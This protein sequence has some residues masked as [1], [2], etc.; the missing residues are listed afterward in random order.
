[1]YDTA[2]YTWASLLSSLADLLP[3]FGHDLPVNRAF[4]DGPHYYQ[5]I[6]DLI[7]TQ[8]DEA[9]EEPKHKPKHKNGLPL[10]S[11]SPDWLCGLT[12]LHFIELG[13]AI[14]VNGTEMF[15]A[16]SLVQNLHKSDE[17]LFSLVASS[18]ITVRC[19]HDPSL[20]GLRADALAGNVEFLKI[21]SDPGPLALYHYASPCVTL[22]R[23]ISDHTE[24]AVRI[25]LNINVDKPVPLSKDDV[26][27]NYTEFNVFLPHQFMEL[28]IAALDKDKDKFM[29]CNYQNSRRRMISAK[30]RSVWAEMK[31]ETK[32]FMFGIPLHETLLKHPAFQPLLELTSNA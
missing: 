27:P 3:R 1:M 2:Y 6:N 16:L 24:S 17:M 32:R 10:P 14:G 25:K 9:E 7:G 29:L 15:R 28:F 5:H 30:I 22:H 13:V 21:L 4:P 31:A 8:P 12:R 20:T 23:G 26:T 11:D 18:Q 19:A